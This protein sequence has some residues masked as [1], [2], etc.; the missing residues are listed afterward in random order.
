MPRGIDRF[1]TVM[2]EKAVISRISAEP[3]SRLL[4]WTTVPM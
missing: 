1:F 4:L 3:M 2:T